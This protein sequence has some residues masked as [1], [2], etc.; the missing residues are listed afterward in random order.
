MR[1]YEFR[2]LKCEH[3]FEDLVRSDQDTVHCPKCGSTQVTRLLS[4]VRRQSPGGQSSCAPSTG[5]S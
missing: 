1:L 2:C 3:E 4:A 5:F